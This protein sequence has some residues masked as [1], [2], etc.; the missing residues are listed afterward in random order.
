MK[1]CEIL[2]RLCC[3]LHFS[4][5]FSSREGELICVFFLLFFT[6]VFSKLQDFHHRSQCQAEPRPITTRWRRVRSISN[7]GQIWKIRSLQLCITAYST[8]P[9]QFH[10]INSMCSLMDAVLFYCWVLLLSGVE[11]A[12]LFIK[13]RKYY[14]WDKKHFTF[15]KSSQFISQVIRS[16]GSTPSWQSIKMEIN[17]L[18]LTYLTA[19]ITT[20]NDIFR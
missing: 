12:V 20:L 11:S 13:G 1:G 9:H 6:H 15:Q 5:F 14:T 16:A 17:G 4:L 2:T 3:F 10:Y 18:T 8:L 7:K 19:V